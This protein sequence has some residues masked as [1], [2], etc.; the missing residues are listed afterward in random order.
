MKKKSPK[1]SAFFEPRVFLSFLLLFGAALLAFSGFGLPAEAQGPT[2]RV[3]AM[4]PAPSKG[5]PDV[6]RMV[7][8]VSQDTDLRQLPYIPASAEQ[9]EES[10]RSR[11]PFPRPGGENKAPDFVTKTIDS[12]LRPQP[13]IPSPL[14]TF[15]GLDS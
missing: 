10:P 11:Y 1:Y 13:A 14:F 8:P 6:V 3:A 7:G 9:D 15:E 2:P 12:V 5:G 4:A